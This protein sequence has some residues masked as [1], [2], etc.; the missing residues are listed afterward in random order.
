MR[1]APH[2]LFL[3]VVALSPLASRGDQA[4][5]KFHHEVRTHDERMRDYYIDVKSIVNRGDDVFFSYKHYTY[6]SHYPTG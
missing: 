1:R 5:Y 2:W 6:G 4:W 3:L